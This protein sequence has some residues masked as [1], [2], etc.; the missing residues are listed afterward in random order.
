VARVAH[1][2][3]EGNVLTMHNVRNFHYSSEKDFEEN[4]ETRRYNIDELQ[5]L[6]MFFHTGPRNIL[7]MLL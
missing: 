5:G 1:G 7:L 4:W 3:I 2:E 6:D